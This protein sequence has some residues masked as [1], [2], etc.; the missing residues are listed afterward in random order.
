MRITK[1][2][3]TNFRSFQKKQTIEFAPVTLLF[4][5]NSVGKSTVLMALFYVQHIL[6]NGDCSPAILGNLN[7]KYIGGFKNLING[8]DLEQAITLRIEFSKQGHFGSNYSELGELFEGFD[9]GIGSPSE[10]AEVVAVEFEIRWSEIQQTAYVAR[11]RVAFDGEN[12]AEVT[13]DAGLKQ[14]LITFIN[15]LHP[16]LQ[17]EGDDERLKDAIE[18][19]EPLHPGLI[20]KLSAVLKIDIP[21]Y[22]SISSGAEETVEVNGKAL[23]FSEEVF[24]N[25]FHEQLN[26]S[27]GESYSYSSEE[28]YEF[29]E[30]ELTAYPMCHVPIA[31][32]GTSGALPILERKLSLSLNLEDTDDTSG[33]LA[34]L[35]RFEAR[36]T[37]ILSDLVVAPL[38]DL[39]KLLNQSLCIGPI[40]VV[41]DALFQFA[42]NFSQKQW[43][44]GSA[45]W[46]SLVQ[47]DQ[48]LLE[49]VNQWMFDDSKLNLGYGLAVRN[50]ESLT[51]VSVVNAQ[52]TGDLESKY[53]PAQGY[54]QQ[55]KVALWDENNEID[56]APNEVGVGISQIMPLVVAALSRKQGLIACEQ[57]E[58]HVHPRIQVAIADLLTQVN[59]NVPFLIETHSEHLILRLLRRVRQTSEGELPEGMNPVLPSDI[60]ITYLESADCGVVV[61]KIEI[62]EDGEF[63][64][65]W[66]RGFFSE[67]REE[68]I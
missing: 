2:S 5:P 7:D 68:L 25:E 64:S 28:G 38:D 32:K 48:A 17:P 4:G 3:L 51:K 36:A 34:R 67:R 22:R 35:K 42:P 41:P 18:C 44:D 45:A 9:L 1:L 16:L 8:R 47:A 52:Q 50:V 66:P 20:K 23:I 39:L 21:D 11:Y 54:E 31:F 61:R 24:V 33:G 6:Q 10:A 27:R 63:T 14:P 55:V 53:L 12:I 37:E 62:D 57:P 58:L 26:D 49:L 15:Y 40:R 19:E 29:D 60:S 30:M 59:N 46:H 56:V 13:S 65:R 43:Y